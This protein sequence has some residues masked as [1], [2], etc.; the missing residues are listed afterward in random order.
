MVGISRL[1]AGRRAKAI[2]ARG[3]RGHDGAMTERATD[4]PPL[5]GELPRWNNPPVPE[6]RPPVQGPE[7]DGLSPTRYGD[8]EKNGIA[9]DF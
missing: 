1:S 4:R 6:P 9:V 5:T 3:H 8:W 2:A 7:H